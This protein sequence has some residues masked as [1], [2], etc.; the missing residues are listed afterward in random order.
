MRRN[1]FAIASAYFEHWLRK[2]DLYSQQS[3]FIFS[4]FQGALTY[5][6]STQS[7]PPNNFGFS[8]TIFSTPSRNEIKK[9]P[10]F[11]LSESSMHHKVWLPRKKAA[12]LCSYLCQTTAAKQVMEVGTGN[13]A[14]T[15]LLDQVVK[16]QLHTFSEGF[17][18]DYGTEFS[19][20]TSLISEFTLAKFTAVLQDLDA[21]DFLIIH[22]EFSKERIRE[23]LSQCLPRMQSNGI[24]ALGGIHQSH[25]MAAC[26]EEIK[27]DRRTT[28]TL[29]FFDYG[30]AFFDYSG[31]K[32]NLC[33][34]Y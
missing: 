31:P 6:K 22:P 29:D 27:N 18:F 8:A 28:L 5:L 9:N 12:F 4:L 13:G 21:L 32:I 15:R 16:G 26:W 1:S 19:P 7:S 23:V 25:A 2:E 34:G 17:F 33:L 20:N 14:V 3:P 30:F 24:V 11:S 10:K